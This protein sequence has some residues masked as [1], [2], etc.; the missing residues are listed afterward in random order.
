MSVRCD[1]CGKFASLENAEP[2]SQSLEIDEGTITYQVRC[3]RICTDCGDELKE[4]YIDG[5][6]D[7]DIKE[8]D[9]EGHDL[10]VTEESIESTER[11]EGK[12]RFTKSF[13]GFEMSIE[14]VCSC[15]QFTETV[16]LTDDEQASNFENMN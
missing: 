8:H 11:Y 14:V 2:E 10:E 7:I 12:G 9:G 16:K 4:A 15:G 1:S 6:H 3:I 5:S 13:Y